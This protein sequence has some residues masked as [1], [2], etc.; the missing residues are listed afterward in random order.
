M[1]KSKHPIQ[2]SSLTRAFGENYALQ[3]VCVT[4][5]QGEFSV[6]LGPSG[7]GKSTLLRLIAGLDQQTSGTIQID[8]KDVGNASPND[9]NVSMVFQSY[10][11]FPHLN[12]AENILFGL[13]VRKTPKA[14]R[15]QRLTHVAEMMGLSALLDRK[16][17]QLSGGQQQRVALARAVISERSIC[18]MDEP[19]SN[20]DAKL[21]TEMRME[22]RALQQQLGLTVVYVT[23]DQV[24]A[25]TMADQIIVMNQGRIE[26]AGTPHDI[27]TRPATTFTAGFIGTPPM[28][29]FDPADL[30]GG[31]LSDV[32]QPHLIGL[33]AEDMRVA[34]TGPTARISGIEYLGADR[35]I[36]ATVGQTHFTM[37]MPASAPVPPHE[38][39]LGWSPEAISV[40]AANG[41]R[42]TQYDFP[43]PSLAQKDTTHETA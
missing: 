26:Q 33:R 7:C 30:A 18:L 22:L 8:G 40:F 29:L 34:P 3:D 17:A 10:A 41:Q 28:A 9:R 14:E 31:P 6:L 39:S 5:K 38:F 21:R 43:T 12:V 16:P 27:Y 36:S 13:R 32:P 35:L 25:M 1:Q 24:E 4:L 42:L 2:I 15:T 37:R 11:L 19:L 20:L 23:H